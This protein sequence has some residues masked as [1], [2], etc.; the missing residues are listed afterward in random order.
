M[1]EAAQAAL[2]ALTPFD[3][4]NLLTPDELTCLQLL[5]EALQDIA[6]GGDISP[7]IEGVLPHKL[8]LWRRVTVNHFHPNAP[9]K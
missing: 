3:S 2:E 7:E 9:R 4:K 8:R 6:K 1:K 5:R